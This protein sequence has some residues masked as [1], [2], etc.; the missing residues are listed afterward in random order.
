MSTPSSGSAGNGAGG[1][2]LYVH[3]DLGG[4]SE[5]QQQLVVLSRQL[6]Q[7]A[8]RF[9]D[10]ERQRAE[11]AAIA[12]AIQAAQ[13]AEE[14][15]RKGREVQEWNA[16]M[17]SLRAV[18]IALETRSATTTAVGSTADVR[19]EQEEAAGYF[20]QT[21]PSGGPGFRRELTRRGLLDRLGQSSSAQRA[22]DPFDDG[23]SDVPVGFGFVEGRNHPDDDLMG[24]SDFGVPKG[25]K[26]QIPIF[27]GTT[28]SWG[29]FEM[30]FLMAMRHLRLDSVLSG[31]KEEVPVADRT[32]SRDRLNAH[33]GKL[34]VAKHF[35]VWSLISS[36][37][38]TDADK[39]VF[40]VQ[41]HQWLVGRES[42]LFIVQKPKERSSSLAERFLALAFSRAKIL[43]SS[44][45]R[46]WN[47]LPHW[48]R[49][50]YPCTKRLSACTSLTTFPPVTSLSRTTCKVRRSHLHA[51][52]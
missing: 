23:E 8:T 6:G 40:S 45:A 30:E 3:G 15:R 48:T 1:E 24:E 41:S 52:C 13:K 39:R 29:R 31:D 19:Q 21:G 32:I 34:K 9:T 11:E 14:E 47:C 51:L 35:A 43:P 5:I 38:K 42:L 36:S 27:D 26:W 28:T 18:Q 37:L 17:S 16:R 22:E 4:M 33:F 7:L 10:S 20:Q 46:S 2:R 49:W 50:E 12:A 44:S 25:V